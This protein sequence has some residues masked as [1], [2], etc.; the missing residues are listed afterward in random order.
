MKLKNKDYYN[1][2]EAFRRF[3]CFGI[4][5]GRKW[6]VEDIM[7][8]WTGLGYPSE[9]KTTVENG[10]M[11]PAYLIT[12]PR[13]LNWYCLTEMGAA[14]IMYWHNA[15]FKCKDYETPE[16]FREVDI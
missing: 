3:E 8:E 16:L 5:D 13:V 12:K 10:F 7:K 1:L 2:Q 4:P 14:V 9:Y 11:K 15:G 6:T